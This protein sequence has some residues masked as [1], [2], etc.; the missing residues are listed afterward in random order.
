MA[1]S[2]IPVFR[3]ARRG[4]ILR[5]DDWNGVQRELRN[6]VRGH[7]HTRRA[8]DAG[9]DAANE[10][11]ARQITTDEI[12]DGAVTP[13]KLSNAAIKSFAREATPGLLA[14]RAPGIAAAGSANGRLS[15]AAGA[16]ERVD[17][18]LGNVPVGVLV[19]VQQKVPGLRGDFDVYGP[20]SDVL[21]A[22]PRKP[23]GSF[24]L[25][26]TRDAE[27]AV[28]WWAFAGEA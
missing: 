5:S 23:N 16:K 17:H 19:G 3:E 1:I 15:L 9:D 20:A 18:G 27:V 10:D 25:V 14:G 2:D 4:Q 7:R 8:Q 11:E 12:A 24:T 21:A 28:R 26:S 13:E 22:V 6:S